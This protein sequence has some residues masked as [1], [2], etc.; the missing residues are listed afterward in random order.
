MHKN[1]IITI[2]VFVVLQWQSQVLYAQS[3]GTDS[4][5]YSYD[6]EAGQGLW[7][8]SDGLWSVGE[9]GT[10]PSY[11]SR[12]G[13][14]A[15]GVLGGDVPASEFDTYLISPPIVLPSIN[16][17]E[18]LRLGFIHWHDFNRYVSGWVNVRI[19]SG[20][21]KYGDWEQV[22]VN[23]Y[24]NLN[25]SYWKI[26]SIIISK[27]KGKRINV[28]FR[29]D[30]WTDY[31]HSPSGR[32]WRI[33]DMRIVKSSF[34][35]NTLPVAWDFDQD[36]STETSADSWWDSYGLFCVGR[37]TLITAP[38]QPNCAGTNLNIST[39]PG[40]GFSVYFASPSV[41]I[42]VM[43]WEDDIIFRFRYYLDVNGYLV[44]QS[45]IAEDSGNGNWGPW[46]L[47]A[48]YTNSTQWTRVPI[49][50]PASYK[51]KTV[52]F[53]FA[54]LSWTDSL[55][56]AIGK[57]FYVDDVDL[58]STTT[59]VTAPQL[60]IPKNSSVAMGTK[61]TFRW[62][63]VASA[64]NYRIQVSKNPSFATTL[65]DSSDI[66]PTSYTSTKNLSDTAGVYYWR[67][68]ATN[69]LGTSVWSDVW[70]FNSELTENATA[71]QLVFPNNGS[72]A[73]GTKP[74]FRWQLVASAFNYRIQV[75]K[76]PSFATTLLDSSDIE[77]T[78]YTSTK[79][80]S[81]TASVYY[82]RV[83]ATN[84]LGAGVWS[85]V[86]HFNSELTENA[87]APHLVF[88]NNGSV[89][90]GT[91]PTFRWQLVAS[92]FNYRIQVSKDSLFA[93]TLL[94]SSDI[95]PTSYT[96]TKDL[97]D[98]VSTYYWRVCATNG[99]GTSVWS[100][101]WH[102]NS[103]L[104]EVKE[105]T[106]L[107]PK[108]FSLQQNYPNPFNPSTRI[109]FSLPSK[110]FVSLKVFD[111]IGREVATLVSEVLSA[112]SYAKQWNAIDMPSGIYFYRL[113]ADKFTE[114]KKLILLR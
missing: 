58:F 26:A 20:G 52:R 84:G 90:I 18:E 53:G 97:P 12:P 93:T 91:K 32:G 89:A 2:A 44:G 6:F 40:T 34:K 45:V 105:I 113:Q 43:A 112:G 83:C 108:V 24:N 19:D 71:P 23:Y 38:S 76:N 11:V 21:G 65:L 81:D 13:R 61:P 62:R 101:V 14:M 60:V 69:G 98:T 28:G 110:S 100:N 8:V 80:L 107:Q 85:D 94:D 72:V 10:L 82:W 57:G 22:S 56:S 16:A 79:D 70:H 74:T 3:S 102:F 4:I 17:N 104:T 29:L 77:P 99:L 59:H 109:S 73:I 68:C 5:I 36:W 33:D 95:E 96:S 78:S 37:D 39:V 9:D 50:L 86:W 41:Q 66:E 31:L 75:S 30:G 106:A 42:P 35:M 55:G 15:G 1:I 54:L 103:S 46:T 67:V 27:Y 51:G 114:T 49:T 25:L 111:L 47:L 87:T 64:F 7:Q 88:P 63:L 92:A 48:Q